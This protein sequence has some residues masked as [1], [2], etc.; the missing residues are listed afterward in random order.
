MM[1]ISLMVSQIITV[2]AIVGAF[3]EHISADN[4]MYLVNNSNYA[5]VETKLMIWKHYAALRKLY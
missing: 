2:Y 5:D 4:H 1:I 3:D